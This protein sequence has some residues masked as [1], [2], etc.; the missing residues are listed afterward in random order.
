METNFSAH[1][2]STPFNAGLVVLQGN[3]LIT[4]LCYNPKVAEHIYHDLISKGVNPKDINLAMSEETHSSYFPD[5]DIS[6]ANFGN[7]SLEGLGLGSAIGG[8]VGA[9]T[10]AVAALGSNLII[11]ALGIV[12]AGSWAAALAGAGAGAAT[13]GLIGALIGFGI[14]DEQAEI[15]EEGINNGGILIGVQI[16]SEEQRQK[17]YEQLLSRHN[18]DT[19]P[20]NA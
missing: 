15:L 1:D 18:K 14:T 10:A 7:K 12:V 3:G 8:T 16:P 5:K 2:S 19:T 11:P 13:G 4:A 6:T 20:H 9:L 17:I